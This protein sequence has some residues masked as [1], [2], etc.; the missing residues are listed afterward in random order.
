MQLKLIRADDTTIVENI[1][2]ALGIN[3]DKKILPLI[4]SVDVDLLRYNFGEDRDKNNVIIN[5]ILD[6]LTANCAHIH[7][8]SIGHNGLPFVSYLCTEAL[9]NFKSSLYGTISKGSYIVTPKRFE[10]L[11]ASSSTSLKRLTQSAMQIN[12]LS[13]QIPATVT[14]SLWNYNHSTLNTASDMLKINHLKPLE[15]PVA[16]FSLIS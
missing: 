15:S 5:T 7:N 12:N 14:N 10:G 1:S 8:I 4:Y 3:E 6:S 9:Y 2:C 11:L 16:L 13:E